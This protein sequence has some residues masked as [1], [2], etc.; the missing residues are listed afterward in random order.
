[1]YRQVEKAVETGGEVKSLCA[2]I[3]LSR[4]SYYRS[5]RQPEPE[6]ETLA[7]RDELQKIALAFPS[8]GYRRITA[9]LARRGY[10]ANHKRVL[11]QMRQDN[12][13]CLRRKSF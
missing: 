11:R 8:Y 6:P 3:E 1:M 2:A 4:A 5:L 7:L 12:L 10:A 13:L 9:E